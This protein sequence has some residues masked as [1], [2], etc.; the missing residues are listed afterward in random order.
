MRKLFVVLGLGCSLVTSAACAEPSTTL[1]DGLRAEP[2][3]TR[4][5]LRE[6]V[7]FCK[8][9]LGPLTPKQLVYQCADRMQTAQ[10]VVKNPA[11]SEGLKA[12]ERARTS[13]GVAGMMS[14]EG[15]RA[16]AAEA[17]PVF[18]DFL[19]AIEQADRPAPAS[20]KT[21]SRK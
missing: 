11:A 4:Q 14:V 20:K 1:V 12:V 15:G 7:S 8:D 9:T 19:T 16:K 6:Y 21:G 17:M 10:A 5:M 2:A 13:A 18:L 3:A